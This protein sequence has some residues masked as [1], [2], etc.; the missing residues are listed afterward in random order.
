VQVGVPVIGYRLLFDPGLGWAGDAALFQV[1]LAYLGPVAG[2][3][4]ALAL[5]R[6]LDRPAAR[7]VL[8]TGA[9]GFAGIAASVLLARGIEAAGD[10]G[11]AASHWGLSLQGTIWMIVALVQVARVQLPGPLA[12]VRRGLAVVA[13]GL[14]GMFWLGGLVLQSPLMAWGELVVGPILLNTLLVAYGVPAALM[15]AAALHVPGLA[16]WGR[17]ALAIAGGALALVWAGLAIRHAWQGPDLTRPGVTDGELYSYTIALILLG[18]G[19][20][21]Q[22]IRLRSALVR[23]V[24]M[25]VI[26][27]TAAK[28]FLIDAGGLTG[29]TRV[30]SFLALGL[31]LAGLAWLNRWA[32]DRGGA[33]GGES[34]GGD[35]GGE[36]AVSA[37]P[38]PST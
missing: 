4:A 7:L 18:A 37:P 24:A 15:V 21:W 38:D 25:A 35:A 11:D 6:G 30:F 2:C 32:A 3:V 20:L 26:G 9:A 31:S 5:I 33:N 8:E 28:V 22:A 36:A 10:L 27:L 29:L 17:R 13:F 23:R 16:P 1:A 12:W 34:G 19:L 14:A